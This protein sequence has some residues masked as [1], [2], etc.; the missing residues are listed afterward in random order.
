MRPETFTAHPH[1][2]LALSNKL[3]DTM[4]I[5]INKTDYVYQVV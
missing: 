3:L 4:N 1:N 2:E 5:L